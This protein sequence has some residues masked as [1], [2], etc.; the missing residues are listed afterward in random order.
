MAVYMYGRIRK[1]KSL[2]RKF[3]RDTL[4]R[5]RPQKLESTLLELALPLLWNRFV[6][7]LL[8]D[9]DVQLP[10]HQLHLSLGKLLLSLLQEVLLHLLLDSRAI[11]LVFT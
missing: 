5:R 9:H 6:H 1:D 10:L 11:Q 2:T 3:L 8:E 7:H 4:A